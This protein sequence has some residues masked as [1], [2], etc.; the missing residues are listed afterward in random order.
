MKSLNDR[1]LRWFG[2]VGL[3]AFVS[4]FFRFDLYATSTWRTLLINVVIGITAGVVCWQL[5]RWVVLTIQHRY[6]GLD[7]TRQRLLWLL[8]VLPV[9]VGFAWLLRHFLRFLIEGTFDYYTTAI[10]LSRNIGIQI[11][12][13][14]IYF[15]IYEGWYILQQWQRETV[16]TSTL[17][18]V[19]LQSQLASLQHQVNPHFLFNSLNSLSSLIGD[20]P[21]QADTFLGELT[22]VFRYLLQASEHQ[23]VPLSD[24]IAFIRSYFHLLQTRYQDGLVLDLSD[25]LAEKHGLIPPLALQ[26]LIENAVRYN[27]ILP[28]NPLHIRIYTTLDQRLH[29]ANTLQRKN[30][31]VETAGAG[32][33]N[34]ATR[35]ELLNEGS[36]LIEESPG[37]F[38]VSLPLVSEGRLAEM[39]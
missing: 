39:G 30:L 6:P 38:V 22:A 29:V 26:V 7:N 9:L 18:K 28:D 32:L 15:A 31:R 16:Q 20:D 3:Y 23:L 27:V 5:A 11:F 8:A 4:L 34:L 37:W 33:S 14:F 10:E 17:E 12:Y 35:Y 2:P 1:W 13:H 24:E 25:D 36:L 21:V 19:S